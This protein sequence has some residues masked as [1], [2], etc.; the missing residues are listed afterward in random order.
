MVAKEMGEKN[1]KKWEKT[2]SF[3][4]TVF[5]QVHSDFLLR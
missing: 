5:A 3:G 1:T 4:F 2:V